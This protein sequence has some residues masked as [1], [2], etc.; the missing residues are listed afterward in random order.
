MAIAYAN[1]AGTSTTATTSHVV[2]LPTSIASGDF[3]LMVMY[4]GSACGLLTTPV[5]WKQ[6][7]SS[8]AVWPSYEANV[9]GRVCD[10]TEGSTET[11]T[12]A[13][14]GDTIT[15]V[16]RF[17]GVDPDD[18]YEIGGSGWQGV[19]GSGDADCSAGKMTNRTA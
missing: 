15:D 8:E 16:A 11:V 13:S 18:P 7:F 9:F 2:T 5:G 14:S 10:G 12:S 3:L 6:I 4:T 17:T 19:Y 1:H